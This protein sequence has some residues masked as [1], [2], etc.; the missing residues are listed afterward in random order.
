MVDAVKQL[1]FVIGHSATAG[2][3]SLSDNF[4][5]KPDNRNTLGEFAFLPFTKNEMSFAYGDGNALEARDICLSV[6]RNM[7][8][9]NLRAKSAILIFY[10]EKSKG[11]R[12]SYSKM[13]RKGAEFLLNKA[14]DMIYDNL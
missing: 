6:V 7:D 3:V 13:S 8:L 4:H 5:T 11:V 14:S 1:Q 12:V 10:C 9:R 2:R